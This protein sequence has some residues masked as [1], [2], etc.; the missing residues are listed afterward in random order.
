MNAADCWQ[1]EQAR[2]LISRLERLSADSMWA[3]RSSGIRG[4]LLKAVESIEGGGNKATEDMEL[5]RQ[6]LAD[7]QSLTLYGFQML[8]KAAR[9]ISR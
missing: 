7:L 1:V 6:A 5:H 9:E 4:A 3:H 2:M 8:E